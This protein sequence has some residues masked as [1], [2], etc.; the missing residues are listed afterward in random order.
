MPVCRLRAGGATGALTVCLVLLASAPAHADA[1]F[2]LG[3]TMTPEARAARGVALGASFVILGFEFEY[4]TTSDDPANAAP[5][6]KTGMGNVYAQTPLGVVQFYALI[7][8][9]LYRER[10]GE[11]QETSAAT[12][13]GG[14]AKVSLAGPL[15]LRLDYRVF[16]LRGQPLHTRVHRMY[17]GLNLLF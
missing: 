7:G 9:G 12:S 17:A 10:L 13:I 11:D 8:A 3:S 2:F 5:G 16:N 6:L 14:G 15:R 1:T 4:S